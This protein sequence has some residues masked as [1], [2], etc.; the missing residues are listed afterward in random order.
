MPQCYVI[1]ALPVLLQLHESLKGSHTFCIDH[2]VVCV[3]CRIA[4]L[5]ALGLESSGSGLAT[6][7]GACE[8]HNELYGF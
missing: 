5:V 6:V 7:M 1:C 2:C 8:H 3:F 4:Q